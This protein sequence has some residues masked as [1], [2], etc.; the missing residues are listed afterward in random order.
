[1]NVSPRVE[2]LRCMVR[3][4]VKDAPGASTL[5][6]R[7]AVK[8]AGFSEREWSQA[9]GMLIEYG[10]IAFDKDMRVVPGNGTINLF[11]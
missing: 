9:I 6:W 3:E 1:M 4:G 5:E 7:E 8:Y 10:E 2:Q 11:Y